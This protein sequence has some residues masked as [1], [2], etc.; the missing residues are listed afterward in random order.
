MRLMISSGTQQQRFLP[1][2]VAAAM[3]SG[4]LVVLGG[5]GEVPHPAQ[6][7]GTGEVHPASDPLSTGQKLEPLTNLAPP[8]EATSLSSREV[9]LALPP[10]SVRLPA[11][12]PDSPRT[13]LS[14]AEWL[15]GFRQEALAAG[16]SMRT[17]ERA[18]EGLRPNRQIIAADRHVTP[19]NSAGHGHVRAYLARHVTNS[20]IANGRLMKEK[21][22]TALRAAELHFGVPA[23]VILAIWGQE[24]HYGAN[25]GRAPVITALA[26]LAYDGRRAPLFRRELLAALHLIEQGTVAVDDWQG[27]W[28]GAFGQA[29]FLP[30][31]YLNYAVDGDGDS[32]ID[33]RNNPADVIASIANYLRAA[34]WVAGTSW[35]FAVYLPSNFDANS[36]RNNSEAAECPRVFARQS[37]PRTI[38]AWRADGVQLHGAASDWPN[39]SMEARLLL[40]DGDGGP[41]YLILPNFRAILAYNCSNYY[42]LSVLELADALR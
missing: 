3:A 29:Q 24:T 40:P 35:G 6:A 28:A 2:D 33:I 15:S 37:V 30:S 16:I 8:R 41:A 39:E 1:F 7:L 27:S 31:A 9:A 25:T 10:L 12:E 20:L 22:L 4:A 21:N 42:A 19:P 5:C 18:F 26:S 34:G 32:K 11:A 36:Y 13:T 17:L 23:E 14:F 38:A